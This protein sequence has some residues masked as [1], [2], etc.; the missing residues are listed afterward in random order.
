MLRPHWRIYSLISACSLSYEKPSQA[1]GLC[2]WEERMEHRHEPRKNERLIVTING[3]DKT[4]HFFEQR[5]EASRISG[6]GALLSGISRHVR[7]GDVISVAYGGKESR[8]KIV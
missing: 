1:A 5:V 6:S 7:P 3:R 4:G 8:F 2:Y